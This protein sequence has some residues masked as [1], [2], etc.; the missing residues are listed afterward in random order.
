M[1]NILNYL[2]LPRPITAFERSYLA[3]MN[4]VGLGFFIA[5]LP[6][7]ALV[8]YA[9]GTGVLYASVLTTL[10]LLGPIAAYRSFTNPRHIS[11]TYGFTAML[12]GGLLVHFGQGPVQIEMHFYFFVLLA[13]LAVY[14]NPMVVIVAAGTAAAHHLVLWLLLP[15]SVFNY[16]APVW[17]V[18]VHALFVVLE[19]VAACF[20]AR[21]FFDNVI[22]LETIIAQRTRELEVKQADMR[23]VLDNVD[24]ALFTIDREAVVAGET[25]L[26]TRRWLC[27][28]PSSKPLATVLNEV[29]PAA[30]D[31]FEMSWEQVKDGFLPLEVALEQLPNTLAS[32]DGR[33]LS[34]GYKPIFEEGELARVLVVGSD[35]TAELKRARLEAEQRET[36]ETF[37]R[38]SRDRQAFSDFFEEADKLVST[39]VR[40][41]EVEDLALL[42][43]RIH[44]LKG[45][46]GIFGLFSIA[47]DCHD[48]ETVISETERAPSVEE[49]AKLQSHWERTRATVE[50]FLGNRAGVEIAE[51]EFEDLLGAALGKMPHEE[52]ASRLARYKLRSA[53]SSLERL[54]E[55][56]SGLAQRLGKGSIGV[57]V[58]ADQ[59]F[60]DPKQWAPFWSSLVHAVRNAVDHG[61]ESEEERIA[62][63]KSPEGNLTLGA[64]FEG[65]EFVVSIADDGRGIDWNRLEVS[66]RS[67][68]M[69]HASRSDLVAVLFADG[70]STAAEVTD[71]SGR[72]IGMGALREACRS[73]GGRVEIPELS[74]CGTKLE[75]RFPTS[76]ARVDAKTVLASLAA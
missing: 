4:R 27:E 48:L 23:L 28:A 2:V 29:S 8:A 19:S 9:N 6:I 32:N 52:L 55:Q 33:T 63:S 45:N 56:A 26:A 35:V 30:G 49:T 47:E 64:R 43:R 61:L 75:F 62:G 25:S 54:G 7:M 14:A 50:R 37:E 22:G 44:T 42:K 17:V 34:L 72:G 12:M 24:Q 13:L 18:A 31:N 68:G 3:R 20:I 16:A 5:H 15:A 36:L 74:T 70:V 73:L 53:R 41:D 71:I 46:A 57:K 38:I 39:I 76:V 69:A 60:L 59:A 40:G 11:M 67:R 10:M 65:D 58:Q 1:K 51:A 66:A 21:S